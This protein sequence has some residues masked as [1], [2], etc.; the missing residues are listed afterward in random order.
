M[1]VC[2]VRT[3]IEFVYFGDEM[4][5]VALR[6]KCCTIRIPP[7][8]TTTTTTTTTIPTTTTTTLTT[9]TTTTSATSTTYAKT[10]T[11]TTTSFTIITRFTT[12]KPKQNISIG[13]RPATI[14]VINAETKTFSPTTPNFTI[15]TTLPSTLYTNL[16]PTTNITAIKNMKPILTNL[17]TRK[18]YI[19][20]KESILSE[21]TTIISS[22]TIVFKLIDSSSKTIITPKPIDT[23]FIAINNSTNVSSENKLTPT[24]QNFSASIYYTLPTTNTVATKDINYKMP[25]IFKKMLTTRNPKT[26]FNDDEVVALSKKQNRN[27][28][29]PG[30]KLSSIT[31]TI[32]NKT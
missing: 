2:A 32:Y 14:N 25:R 8:P 13:I 7:R 3:K 21:Q 15:P 5:L 28:L 12:E 16:E 29:Y 24:N 17:N 20:P 10:T 6:M 1:V 11:P 4:G 9:K 30:E 27:L 23:A 26:E 19:S 18:P 22:S 31:K